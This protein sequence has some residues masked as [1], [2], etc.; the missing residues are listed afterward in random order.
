MGNVILLCLILVVSSCTAPKNK[1]MEDE[2]LFKGYFSYMA[3]AGLFIDC[4]DNK[5]YP[6]SNEGDYLKLEKEYLKT[7]KDGG[8][9]ILI[10][11]N[12]EIVEKEK[13]EGEGKTK[14]LVVNKFI[15]IFPDKKCD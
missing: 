12:G 7:V 9:K 15:N 2:N 5:K 6:V 3:D 13:I 1:N 11:F 8:E 14:F 4:K 10:T